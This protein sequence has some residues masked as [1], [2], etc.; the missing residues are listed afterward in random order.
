MKFIRPTPFLLNTECVVLSTGGRSCIDCWEPTP[1]FSCT[2]FWEVHVHFTCRRPIFLIESIICHVQNLHTWTHIPMKSSSIVD[3][4]C[5]TTVVVSI[6]LMQWYLSIGIDRLPREKTSRL[7][8][9]L[10]KQ[11]KR[12]IYWSTWRA[13]LLHSLSGHQWLKVCA[14]CQTWVISQMIIV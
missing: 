9:R 11:T 2:S 14:P 13:N 3:G 4:S 5:V 12:P 7:I 1:K 6:S 10:L 8:Y